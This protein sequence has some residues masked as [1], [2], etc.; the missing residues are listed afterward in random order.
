[1][2]AMQGR[3][4]DCLGFFYATFHGI[5]NGIHPLVI[6]NIAIEHWPLKIEIVSFPIETYREFPYSYVNVY[7]MVHIAVASYSCASRRRGRPK[8]FFM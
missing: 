3:N 1:M 8:F 4:R 5:F 7:H 2:H 6:C